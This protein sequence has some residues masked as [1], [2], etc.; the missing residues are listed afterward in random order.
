MAS[1]R[2]L[3]AAAA[4]PFPAVQVCCVRNGKSIQ[5]LANCAHLLMVVWKFKYLQDPDEIW[6]LQKLK[7]AT[8]LE[9]SYDDALEAQDV[10][11]KRVVKYPLQT[12]KE[13]LFA[14]YPVEGFEADA[15]ADPFVQKM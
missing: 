9:V 12:T 2:F 8:F 5:S 1:R 14:T 3:Q 13:E 6:S 10:D 7:G 11:P 4:R 15:R